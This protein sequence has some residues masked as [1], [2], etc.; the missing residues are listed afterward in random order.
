MR[1]NYLSEKLGVK[2]I[3]RKGLGPTADSV[4]ASIKA[5]RANHKSSS[6]SLTRKSGPPL[7]PSTRRLLCLYI[8][9]ANAMSI[10]KWIKRLIGIFIVTSSQSLFKLESLV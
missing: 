9:S 1:L 6:T 10:E 8:I 2:L 4:I 5:E 3:G 7:S